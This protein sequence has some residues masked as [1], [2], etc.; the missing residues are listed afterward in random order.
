[1]KNNWESLDTASEK[2]EPF[3]RFLYLNNQVSI[4]KLKG[5]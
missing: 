2:T 1:M 5:G 3:E 4:S